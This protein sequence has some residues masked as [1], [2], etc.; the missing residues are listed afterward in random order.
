M[1]L[2]S[3]HADGAS[4]DVCQSAATVFIIKYG[5]AIIVVDVNVVFINGATTVRSLVPIN[6]NSTVGKF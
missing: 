2:K 3:L 1:S 4:L 6:S 5:E